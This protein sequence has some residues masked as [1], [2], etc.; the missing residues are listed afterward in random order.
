MQPLV[1]IVV[2]CHNRRDY[3]AR[4]LDS[5]L[6]Q[7]YPNVEVVVVDDGSTDDTKDIVAGYEEQGVRYHF[8][9][10][11][12]V[13]AAR[14]RAA[15]HAR[16]ELIAFQDDDDLMPADRIVNLVA[17]LQLHP[18]ATFAIGRVQ[19]IDANDVPV[20]QPVVPAFSR[21]LD[22]PV[23]V[24]DAPRA[25]LA[26]R[27]PVVVPHATLF[28][29]EVGE[30]VGWFDERFPATCE[31]VD[32]FIRLAQRGPV[33]YIPQVTSLWRRVEGR[34]TLSRPGLPRAYS[35]LLL[36]DKHRN[37]LEHAGQDAAALNARL[38]TTVKQFH[39]HRQLGEALPDGFEPE[40]LERATLRLRRRDQLR[41]R[42]MPV[43]LRARRLARRIRNRLLH[44]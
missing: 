10:S 37:L 12:G 44:R 22:H 42:A 2:L 40:L 13:A 38:L 6:A 19:M 27:L 35:Y 20:G 24:D 41:V 25:I 7:T 5:V 30:Q 34:E 14:T 39:H 28:R 23:L 15:Q 31:D 4:T 29:R 36:F 43:T 21:G 11:R 18:S 3:I 17:A 9:E 33:A 8:Q 1:S 32:F 16:G 26:R